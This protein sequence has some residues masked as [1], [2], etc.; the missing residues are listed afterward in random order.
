MTELAQITVDGNGVERMRLF[1]PS[2]GPWSADL[3]FLEQPD[4]SGQI[5]IEQGSARLVGTVVPRQSGTHTLQRRVRVV[6]GAGGWGN[7]ID[8]AAYHND[9]G[10]SRR[11]I[12]QE[13]A[14]LAGETLEGFASMGPSAFAVDYARER[15]PASRSLEDAAGGASWWVDFAGKTQVAVRSGAP[16]D[17]ELVEV[18]EYD[19][20]TR[21]ATLG[22]DDLAAVSI[23]SILSDRLDTPQT[24]SEIEIDVTSEHMSARA[25]CGTGPGS[26]EVEFEALIDYQRGI[27]LF[28]I[29]AYRVQA[30]NG[31]RIDLRSVE[32]VDGLPN[33]TAIDMWPGVSGAYAEVAVGCDVLV[34]FINGRRDRPIV[35]H[36]APKN[37]NGYTPMSVTVDASGASASIKLGANASETPAWA[38]KMLSE[39]SKLQVALSSAQ[40]PAGT[41]GGPLF[42]AIPTNA[43]VAPSDA[44]SIGAAKTVCE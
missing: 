8:Q 29:Y 20:V 37:G 4:V 7:E 2:R 44:S 27:R 9:A 41:A 18:L 43:Y 17:P 35:T 16:V 13:A 22:L 1:V 36:F 15:G 3:D 28:G 30:R 25:W 34:Q 40:A 24:V 39:L 26:L 11:F 5:T 21:V 12:A 33:A 14:R 42:W 6:G 32:S 10:V 38:S 23:G 31:V 19:P